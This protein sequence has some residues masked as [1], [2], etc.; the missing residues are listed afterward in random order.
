MLLMFAPVRGVM[1]MQQTHCDMSNNVAAGSAVISE[2]SGHDMTGMSMTS[3][4][5]IQKSEKSHD[6]C[7]T[8]NS[9][10]SDC[11]MHISVSLLT[12]KSSYSPN[13]INVPSSVALITDLI[14]KEFIPPFRP[15]LVSHS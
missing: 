3:D 10:V 12:Q 15:P 7:S 11:D 8:S 5:G 9:C 2:H 13:F 6:C 14:K 4:S 1:A